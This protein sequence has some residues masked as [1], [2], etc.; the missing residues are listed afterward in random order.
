MDLSPAPIHELHGCG[1]LFFPALPAP[2]ETGHLEVDLARLCEPGGALPD[3]AKA[4]A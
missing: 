3:P 1:L 2:G 4:M